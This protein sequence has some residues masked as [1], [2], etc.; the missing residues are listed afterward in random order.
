VTLPARLRLVRLRVRHVTIALL[1]LGAVGAAPPA[2]ARASNPLRLV[3]STR[4]D[5]RLE[6]LAFRTPAVAGVT[7]VR[8][9]LPAG[10]DAQTRRRYPV[11]YLLHGAADGYSSWTLKGDAE[12]LTARYPVIVVMP[13]SGTGGGY[14]NWYNGGAGGQPEWETYHID[15]LIP[16]IDRHL[17]TVPTRG[18]RAIAGL[19]M[20]GFGAFS[21]ASRHPD[22]FA[23]AASFSGAID[24]NNVLDIAVTGNEVFGL[25]LT[26]EVRWRAHNPWDLAGNLSGVNLT[27]RTGNGLPGGPYGGGDVVELAVHQM[28][29]SFHDRLVAL[30]IPSIWD[31]YGPGGHTWPYWQRDLRQTLPTLMSVF[32]HPKPPP[33]AFSFTAV[34]PRYG[35]YGFSVAVQRPVLEF[36]T[37]RVRGRNEFSLTGSGSAVVATPAVCSPGHMVAAVVRDRGGRHRRLLRADR[38]GRLRVAL[39]LGPGNRYQQYT[40]LAASTPRHSVTADVRIDCSP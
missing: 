11:L 31:D 15:Q 25:R 27:V 3:G 19:S 32:G 37:L 6:Q 26:E 8:V 38:V 1:A 23:A 22:L 17:R 20:G 39:A 40:A 16:W 4:L 28:S 36:S 7:D 13:D 9:L 35:T 12:Q 2:L 33:S 21:Y 24:T 29:V 34:E 30:G 14:T 5:A 10:Y 18:E